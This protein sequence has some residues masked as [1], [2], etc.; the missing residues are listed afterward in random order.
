MGRD[1]LGELMARY[2]AGENEVFARLYELM[3]PRLY[4]FCARLVTHRTEADDLFQ[5]TF[6]K[7]H[8]SRATYTSGASTLHWAFAIA[9]SAYL[10]RMRYRRR[11][12]EQLGSASDAA[13]YDRVPAG[14][15]GPEAEVRAHHLLAVVTRELGKMS[16][17]LR[18]AY[19]LLKEEELSVKE[20]AAV[21]GTSTDVVKQRAHRAYEQLR[22]AMEAAGWREA[23]NDRKEPRR[24]GSWD[25]IPIRA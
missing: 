14:S 24:D 9:R 2:A 21:L 25:S 15:H 4:R 22:A 13:E 12:P 20:A 10:D 3:A 18:V 7:L 23:S 11:R 16:E 17:K 8:R 1:E 6:L 19:V 5:E